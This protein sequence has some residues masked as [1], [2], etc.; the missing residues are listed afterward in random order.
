MVILNLFRMAQL[1]RTG[2]FGMCPERGLIVC[3][4]V[5]AVSSCGQTPGMR[6]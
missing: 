6:S 1:Q 5:Q 2:V 4:F 3:S